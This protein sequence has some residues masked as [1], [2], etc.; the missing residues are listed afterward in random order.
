MRLFRRGSPAS[1]EPELAPEPAPV[2]TARAERRR[3]QQFDEQAVA[4][5]QRLH[6]TVAAP[7]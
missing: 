5:R 6:E 2:E 7:E 1:H 3:A 4:L